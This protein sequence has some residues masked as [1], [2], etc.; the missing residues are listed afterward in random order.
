VI[1]CVPKGACHLSIF[2]GHAIGDLTLAQKISLLGPPNLAKGLMVTAD[3]NR[4]GRPD[5]ALVAGNTQAMIFI[6]SSIGNLQVH[7]FF[8]LPNASIASSMAWGSFNHDVLP[9]LVFRVFD[10]CGQ[11]CSFAN[12][13][14]IFLNTGSASFVLRDRVGVSASPAGGLIAVTDVNGDN[15][16]DI[17]TISEDVNNA[18]VQYSLN[19]GDGKFDPAVTVFTLPDQPP[20]VAKIQPAG[21]LVRDMNFDSRHDFGETSEDPLGQDLGG[22]LIFNNDN[23]QTSCSPPNSAKLA[24]K[25]CS[26]LANANVGPSVSI[27]GAGNSPAG[28]KRM[29]LWIDGSKQFEEW[30]DQLRA[31][32][33]L[34]KGKHR[35]VVQAVDQDDSFSPA[36]IFVTVR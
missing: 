26:P 1:D 23:A 4:D 8:T 24:A 14:Y 5:V 12:S 18:V 22:W 34:T 36:P 31:T 11:S 29:E 7:S 25:I 21:M 10:V 33:S 6:D 28:V 27:Q 20:S 17:L 2:H 13:A 16:Q 19:H 9:D 32:V 3:F 35:I 15:T 30:N